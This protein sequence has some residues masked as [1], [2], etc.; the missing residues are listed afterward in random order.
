MIYYWYYINWGNDFL[1]S[2]SSYG[3]DYANVAQEE[4]EAEEQLPDDKNGGDFF[5]S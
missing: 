5:K 3:H 4:E 1:A 2:T